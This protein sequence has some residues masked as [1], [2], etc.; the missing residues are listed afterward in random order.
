MKFISYTYPWLENVL[1]SEV[2]KRKINILEIWPWFVVFSGD[3][4]T[5]VKANLWFRTANKVYILLG[6][7][8]IENFDNL[9]DFVYSIDWNYFIP[10]KYWISVNPHIVK[11][12]LS[13]IPSI[14]KIVQKAI[15]KK[16][17]NDSYY[18]FD[19]DKNIEVRID[20]FKD[21][22]RVLLDTSGDP[23]YKR[24]YKENISKAWLKETLTSGILLL[25]WCKSDV[26]FDP[27]CGSWTILIEKAMID[28]NIAPWIFR[29]FLFEKF[30]WVDKNILEKERWR[31]KTREKNINCKYFWFDI[32]EN[33][34]LI[35]RQNIK[36]AGLENFIKVEKADFLNV[37]ISWWTMITNPPY[38]KRIKLDNMDEIY[39]KL[40]NDFSNIKCGWL[41]TWYENINK[42]FY[43]FFK[44][45][46]LSNGWD[47]V[48][49]FYKK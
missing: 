22:V 46:V 17:T 38:N 45:R 18:N 12:K 6:E 24:W 41:I 44:V 35:A 36:K 7:E 10:K 4:S 29:N 11:S 31:A 21:K 27:F 39:E 34:V 16:L 26:F 37:K 9:F 33:M 14:Q 40:F 43:D 47:R 13:H 25:T 19:E 42:K 20:I 49:F 48:K 3:I 15:F 8:N 2:E 1:K 28:K 32:D 5:M 23:L 30:D